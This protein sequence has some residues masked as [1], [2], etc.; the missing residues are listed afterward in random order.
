MSKE[1]ATNKGTQIENLGRAQKPAAMTPI[2]QGGGKPALM[3]PVPAQDQ[4]G[5]KPAAMTPI[6]PQA[7]T[8]KAP[9]SQPQ[10]TQAPKKQD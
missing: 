7:S 3:T 10:P 2:L 5:L 6:T 9:V 1:D 4:L 8:P